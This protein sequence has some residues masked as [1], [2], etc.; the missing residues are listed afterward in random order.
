MRGVRSLA[1]VAC[2]VAALATRAALAGDPPPKSAQAEVVTLRLA[3][4]RTYSYRLSQSV[5]LRV[6]GTSL[7]LQHLEFACAPSDDG[8]GTTE[9]SCSSVWEASVQ[10]VRTETDGTV[11]VS[12]LPSRVSG[13]SQCA[14]VRE[15]AF[16]SDDPQSPRPFPLVGRALTVR[17][18][19]S[20]RVIDATPASGAPGAAKNAVSPERAAEFARRFFQELPRERPRTKLVWDAMRALV[21]EF[22]TPG[23]SIARVE[24]GWIG[25]TATIRKSGTLAV[26]ALLRTRFDGEPD[27]PVTPVPSDA[28]EKAAWRPHV[29]RQELAGEA[30]IDR[31]TGLV[32]SRRTSVHVEARRGEIQLKGGRIDVPASVGRPARTIVLPETAP[33]QDE[34]YEIETLL[35]AVASK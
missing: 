13:A 7:R 31:T 4:G 6:P 28:A 34:T 22:V 24:L 20:G 27:A 14:F 26:D 29:L 25:E 3:A 2:A 15:T 18:T 9:I 35:E 11:V 23:G 1:A 16:D 8:P 33:A 17:L 32:K 30:S 19:P 12:L 5:S 21:P 10:L